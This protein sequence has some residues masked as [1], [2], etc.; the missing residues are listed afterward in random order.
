MDGERSGGRAAARAPQLGSFLQPYFLITIDAP[1]PPE[2]SSARLSIAEVVNAFEAHGH[3]PT[4]LHEFSHYLQ[5]ISTA[6]GFSQLATLHGLTVLAAD[7]H[8]LARSMREGGWTGTAEPPL[9]DWLRDRFPAEAD[10]EQRDTRDLLLARHDHAVARHTWHAGARLGPAPARCGMEIGTVTVELPPSAGIVPI[11]AKVTAPRVVI[12]QAPGRGAAFLLGST[13]VR[14]GMSRA[15]ELCAAHR[16]DRKAAL[17]ELTRQAMVLF[18][19][20][21]SDTELDDQ[22]PYYA[23]FYLFSTYLRDAPQHLT[24]DTFVALCELALIYQD[25][26]S[27]AALTFI[28]LVQ[29]LAEQPAAVPA[30]DPS[31]PRA[32]CDAIARLALTRPID[33]RLALSSEGM[34]RYWLADDPKT[35]GVAALIPQFKATVG[36]A[37]KYRMTRLD[38]PLVFLDLLAPASMAALVTRFLDNVFIAFADRSF[39]LFRD[40]GAIAGHLSRIALFQFLLESFTQPSTRCFFQDHTDWHMCG[41]LEEGTICDSRWPRRAPAAPHPC[42]RMGYVDQLD[43]PLVPLVPLRSSSTTPRA[44]K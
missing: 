17:L 13:D 8:A 19:T 37:Y 11:A 33:Q 4:F 21:R 28:V 39:P 35:G 31:A 38:A 30:L 3:F 15:I 29:V 20:P 23:L 6:I 24:L 43:A 32:F 25:H 12:E 27:S 41:Y 14:E 7:A 18:L 40:P 2:L 9:V 5:S 26:E 44:G 34:Q 16:F 42:P 22:V 36:A 1:A 10:A